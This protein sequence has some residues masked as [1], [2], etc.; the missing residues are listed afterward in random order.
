MLEFRCP[1][2]HRWQIDQWCDR[3]DPLIGAQHVHGHDVVER[4]KAWLLTPCLA[5][6]SSES[7]FEAG[8]VAL[9]P[10]KPAFR[11]AEDEGAKGGMADGKS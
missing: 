8:R 5:V 7:N 4:V 11:L 2:L 1:G 9:G 10:N 6:V 3:E